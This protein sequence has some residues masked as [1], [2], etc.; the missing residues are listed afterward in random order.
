MQL[1]RWQETHTSPAAGELSLQRA[2]DLMYVE[3]RAV[4]TET[5]PPHAQSRS[6]PESADKT[7]IYVSGR[8]SSRPWRFKNHFGQNKTRLTSGRHRPR[9]SC[10]IFLIKLLPRRRSRLMW[11]RFVQNNLS[12]NLS[13]F[14]KLTHRPLFSV[15]GLFTPTTELG[16][17]VPEL[18]PRC[19]LPASGQ[20]CYFPNQKSICNFL[21]TLPTQ[22]KKELRARREQTECFVVAVVVFFLF[23]NV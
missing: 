19:C 21:R 15:F 5:F 20:T 4:E 9:W 7:P 10:Q 13:A 6:T 14:L 3:T 1:R 17:C 16:R 2:P 22:T 11:K 8:V 23:S 12:C 18:R